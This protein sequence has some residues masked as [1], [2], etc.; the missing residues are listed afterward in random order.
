MPWLR[1]TSDGP[2]PLCELKKSSEQIS[3]RL[4]SADDVLSR[5]YR[6]GA[7]LGESS[8][9]A[10]GAHWCGAGDGDGGATVGYISSDPS[11]QL[12]LPSVLLESQ[13]SSSTLPLRLFNQMVLPS[14]VLLCAVVRGLGGSG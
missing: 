1:F 4:P 13:T 2:V 14:A 9:S 12:P 6:C 8:P 3:H 7:V 10:G 11:A 5:Q